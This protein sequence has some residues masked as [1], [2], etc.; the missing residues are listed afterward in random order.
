MC[1]NRLRA[2]SISQLAIALL[3]CNFLSS[4][5]FAKT[6][7]FPPVQISDNQL[8]EL[9]NPDF[10]Q[11]SSDGQTVIFLSTQGNTQELFGVRTSDGSVTRISGE[12]VEGGSVGVDNAETRPRSPVQFTRNGIFVLYTADKNTDGV[13]EL[14]QEF[15]SGLLGVRLNAD[16][17]VGGDVTDFASSS[18]S[19][20]VVYI[21]DQNQDDV[22]DLFSQ[23]LQL[24]D[25]VQLSALATPLS[26][27]VDFEISFNSPYVVYLADQ[28]NNDV[29][30]LYSAPIAGGPTVRLNEDLGV[31]ADVTGFQID[32][33]GENVVYTVDQGVL[34]GDQLF[35]VPITGGASIQL[36]PDVAF[37][38]GNFN[39]VID[40]RITSFST[41]DVV[42][43]AD[44]ITNDQFE[45]F[46]VPVTGGTPVRI[47]GEFFGS[48]DVLEGFEISADGSRVIYVADP[49]LEGQFEL[50]STPLGGGTATQLTVS[51]API[52]STPST[53][54]LP[55]K[56][57]AISRDSQ[58]V[59][60][61]ANFSGGTGQLFSVPIDGGTPISLDAA[62][63]GA[64][65]ENY[66]IK[67]DG[68]QVF[69]VPET[70][71]GN[72]YSVPIGG[73]AAEQINGDLPSSGRVSEFIVSTDVQRVIYLANQNSVDRFDLFSFGELP[74][75]VAAV[76]PNSRSVLVDDTATAFASIINTTSETLRNCRI[77]PPE[78]F[79]GA[80]FNFQTTDPAN[81]ELTGFRRVPVDIP[82]MATQTF[83]F[84]F[85]PRSE[86]EPIELAMRFDCQN[87][88]ETLS[89][90]G[91]NT[92]L[93]SGSA[94][95]VADIIALVASPSNDAILRL[96]DTSGS[97]AFAVA[98]I[99]IGSDADIVA[100][101][102]NG[103]SNAPIN[104]SICE[105]NPED[106]QCLTPAA[107][108]IEASVASAGT[109]TFSV[110][111]T[112]S[113]V[114]PLDPANNRIRVRFLEDGAVRGSTSIAVQ[115]P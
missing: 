49:I 29:F 71:P 53:A 14:F 2:G 40:F 28:D 11:I 102:D 68:T 7:F 27:V 85:V 72:L 82:P 39:D 97:A 36:S 6:P 21:A 4:A 46:S 110:F 23:S 12:I 60:F 90:P 94:T 10:F 35:S 86:I 63:P 51:G 75:P 31:T 115:T 62:A 1:Q 88:A 32:L 61:L 8:N 52:A 54:L 106:G 9:I 64:V 33:R 38:N 55:D 30:E 48:G 74:A 87:T 24:G 37:E 16:L 78:N 47:S 45:L 99:N 81:N 84:D 25:P 5:S 112:A 3:L 98:T 113:G 67:P 96:P 66:Q 76:L 95:P 108:T 101:A 34:G 91:V 43:L 89:I 44:S 83:I 20:F 80:N 69:F 41:I 26:D 93:F 65:S 59:V 103:S 111:V 77:S 18:D 105:T 19:R 56:P 17:P 104:F 114:V 57:F 13:F 70:T 15:P 109:P 42:F 73:G 100:S 79:I 58:Q 107:T 92:L 50:F 22:F